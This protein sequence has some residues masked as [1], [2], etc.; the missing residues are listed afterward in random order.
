MLYIYFVGGGF[1]QNNWHVLSK[2]LSCRSTDVTTGRQ[3]FNPNFSCR[4]IL[5]SRVIYPL[6]SRRV[7]PQR[8]YFCKGPSTPRNCLAAFFFSATTLHSVRAGFNNLSLPSLPRFA[9]S[10]CRPLLYPPCLPLRSFLLHLF[11]LRT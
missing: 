4:N 8:Y 9:F 5:Y 11:A 1:I 10:S 3:S 6:R 7:R 2:R